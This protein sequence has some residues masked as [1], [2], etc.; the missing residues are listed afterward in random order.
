MYTK[1]LE[2]TEYQINL[3]IKILRNYIKLRKSH[4]F[5]IN[6]GLKQKKITDE[7]VVIEGLIIY[8]ENVLNAN[9]R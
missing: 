6:A 2:L 7:L 3:L 4:F 1:K 5:S 9:I 8:F